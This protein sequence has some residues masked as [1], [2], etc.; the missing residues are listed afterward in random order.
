MRQWAL[1]HPA[2]PAAVAVGL[3]LLAGC[4]GGGNG[5][6]G[7]SP[8]APT[9]ASGPAAATTTPDR[10]PVTITPDRAPAT[11]RPTTAGPPT[12][13]PSDPLPGPTTAPPVRPPAGPAQS[14]IS[15]GTPVPDDPDAR[16]AYLAYAQFN[17]LLARLGL[18]PDPD[19][20]LI[21]ALTTG[22]FR[23]QLVQNERQYAA[24]GHTIIG[25][26]RIA[27]RV[28]MHGNRSAQISDC[29]D[30]RGQHDYLRG[31]RQPGNGGAGRYTASM[32]RLGDRWVVQTLTG[33]AASGSCP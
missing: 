20:P 32:V 21:P 6:A 27:P 17:V 18:H 12:A 5:S 1:M 4:T 22:A 19:D 10:V 13:G 9:S 33:G 31:A 2:G 8:T 3:S 28:R 23:L 26:S 15:Y 29:A 11:R 7:S 14:P 24:T 25:P 16:A 30:L